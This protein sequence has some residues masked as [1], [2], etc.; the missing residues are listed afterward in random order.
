MDEKDFENL[1]QK[2]R[3]K[4]RE[5]E[6]KQREEEEKQRKEQAKKREARQ[7]SIFTYLIAIATSI[8]LFTY[9]VSPPREL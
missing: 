7:F 9:H 2:F 1:Y 3:S 8:Y 6:K 4:E 5:E